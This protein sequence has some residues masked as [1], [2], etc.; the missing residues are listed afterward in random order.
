MR[1]T[2]RFFACRDGP[3]F[4]QDEEFVERFA[5]FRQDFVF[6]EI[7]LVFLQRGQKIGLRR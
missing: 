4:F 7:F 5:L 6:V 1:T 2:F 3:S